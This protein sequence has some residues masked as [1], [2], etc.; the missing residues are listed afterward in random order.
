MQKKVRG[1]IFVNKYGPLE[2]LRGG[3]LLSEGVHNYLLNKNS[4]VDSLITP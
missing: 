3:P 2:E 4:S 1:S